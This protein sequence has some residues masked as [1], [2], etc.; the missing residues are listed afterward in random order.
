MALFK[1]DHDFSWW[2]L[3]PNRKCKVCKALSLF[4][5]KRRES[6]VDIPEDCATAAEQAGVGKRVNYEAM[7]Q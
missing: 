3:N 7:Q 5:F 2:G 4:M 1:F 6:P